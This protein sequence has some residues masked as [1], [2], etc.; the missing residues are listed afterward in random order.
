MIRSSETFAEAM[1]YHN[2]HVEPSFTNELY[3]LMEHKQL[4]PKRVIAL[5]GLDRSYFY[6]ILS[7]KKHPG[8]SVVLRICFALQLDLSETNRLLKLSGHNELYPKI[9]HDAVLIFAIEKNMDA[10]EANELLTKSG[11]EPLYAAG[12]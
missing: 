3:E 12:V 4:A 11:E 10:D 7:G 2:E 6:H 5:T 8:R 9:R 1:A